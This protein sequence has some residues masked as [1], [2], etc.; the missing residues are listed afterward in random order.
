[1]LWKYRQYGALHCFDF[2]NDS[3][4][5]WSCYLLIL[6]RKKREK[7]FCAEPHSGCWDKKS[8]ICYNTYF[9]FCEKSDLSTSQSSSLY[10]IKRKK[11][12]PQ[13]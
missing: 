13:L 11:K 2:A 7:D 8:A 5:Y 6:R 4:F 9:Y 10:R 12:E 3:D 1:M